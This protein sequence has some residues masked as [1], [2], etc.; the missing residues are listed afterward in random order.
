M[1]MKKF[2]KFD[3]HQRRYLMLATAIFGSVAV[4]HMVR[5]LF[6]WNLIIG[7][8][9]IPQNI[10]VLAA[11]ITLSMSAMGIGYLMAKN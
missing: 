7:G 8:F 4:L 5:V 6:N 3:M 2:K 1:D 9:E 11:F 10:S